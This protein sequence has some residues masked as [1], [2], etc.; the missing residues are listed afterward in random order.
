MDCKFLIN[1][2]FE[3]IVFVGIKALNRCTYLMYI[4]FSQLLFQQ[5][6]C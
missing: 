3:I 5:M 2:V 4:L 6:V 1:I